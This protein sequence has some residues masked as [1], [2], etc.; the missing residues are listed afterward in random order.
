M[1]GQAFCGDGGGVL[2]GEGGDVVGRGT[3][4]EGALLDRGDVAVVEEVEGFR[5]E[6]EVGRVLDVDG[7]EDAE[8]GG[9]RPG[10]AKGVAADGGQVGGTAGAVDRGASAG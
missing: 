8:V 3:G 6:A 7:A 2:V 5:G 1:R 10:E 9:L 4:E